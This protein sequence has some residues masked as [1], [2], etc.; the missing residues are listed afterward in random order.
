[1]R[2][3]PWGGGLCKSFSP[4]ASLF[5]SLRGYLP[6]RSCFWSALGLGH[7]DQPCEYCV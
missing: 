7:R 1:M 6:R 5:M 2:G 3:P 4:S